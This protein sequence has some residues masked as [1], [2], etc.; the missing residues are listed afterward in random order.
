MTLK[1]MTGVVLSLCVLG[2]AADLAACGDK[3][4][5]ASRGTRF[6]RAGLVRRPASVLVYAAPGG[7]L[8]ASVAQLG[9][10]EALTKVGYRPTVVTDAAEMARQLREGRWD[11]VLVDLADAA[12]LPAAGGTTP[13]PAVVTVAYETSGSTMAQA[14]RSYDA[15][16]K[17]PG[18]SRAVLDAVDDAL[19]ARALR[20]S[21]VTKSSN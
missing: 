1:A 4:L 10:A 21:A 15:V 6:Q 12:A 18:R 19:F 11:L 16:I 17:Q 8:A 13:A 9:I 7:R 3:F 5:V 14:R 20:P 2:Q